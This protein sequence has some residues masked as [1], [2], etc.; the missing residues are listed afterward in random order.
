MYLQYIKNFFFLC[1]LFPAG[2]MAQMRDTGY[3]APG[4]DGAG[5][6]AGWWWFWVIIL[7]I[8]VGIAIWW[9]TRAG[10][11]PTRPRSG[12]GTRV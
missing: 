9:A 3:V 1:M 4:T 6:T 12:A 5:T 10:A 7:L 2:I 8:I 11:P